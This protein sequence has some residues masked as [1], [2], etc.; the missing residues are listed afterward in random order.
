MHA[1]CHGKA[2]F[3]TH[4]TVLLRIGLGHILD[5]QN[6][7]AA[8][9]LAGFDQLTDHRLLSINQVIGKHH[10]KRF[11]T[12]HGLCAKHGVAQA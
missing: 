5:C 7:T 12:Y 10:R 3:H 1:A 6:I 4:N 9:L 2:V 11:V 8:H